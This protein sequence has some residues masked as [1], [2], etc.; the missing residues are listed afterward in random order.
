MEISSLTNTETNL[1][2]CLLLK[3]DD[4]YFMLAAPLGEELRNSFLGIEVEGLADENLSEEA[5]AAIDLDRF[6]IAERVRRLHTMVSARG[7]SID[8]AN[9]PDTEFGRND[10]LCFLEHFL[11]TLPDVALGG[12]DLTGARNGAV[13][14]LYSLSFAW[15]N[16]IE[17]IE[18]AFHGDAE[19]PLSVGDLALLSGL[20]IRTVRNRCGPGKQVRTSADR[21]SRERGKAAPA[22]VSLNA[23]DALE[24]LAGRRDFTVSEIDPAWLTRQLANSDVC[25]AT[26]GLLIASIVNLGSLSTLGNELD[27]TFEDAREWFDQGSALPTRIITSLTTRLGIRN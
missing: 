18:S 21:A 22:F 14:H 1:R 5:I 7:L 27:F 17:T 6:D 19:T 10:N 2:H 4:L 12:M 9:R 25:A 11:S 26:R 20:D 3:A 8:N 16:L 15:L 13:R 24:W 23:L